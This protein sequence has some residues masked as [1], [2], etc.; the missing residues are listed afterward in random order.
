MR[1]STNFTPGADQAA[2]SAA[3]RS[4]QAFT[5]PSSFTVPFVTLTVIAFASSSASRLKASSIRFLISVGEI[6]G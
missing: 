4:A 2:R 3:F 6:S 5:R 1:S